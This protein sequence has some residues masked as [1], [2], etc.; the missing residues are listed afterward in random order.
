MVFAAPMF[1]ISVPVPLR[2]EGAPLGLT[3]DEAVSIEEILAQHEDPRVVEGAAEE[4]A[5]EKLSYL[6]FS[7]IAFEPLRNW[8]GEVRS[9]A[10]ARPIEAQLLKGASGYSGSISVTMAGTP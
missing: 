4:V 2:G 8:L 10:R 9:A 1:C 5:Q 3:D 7:G 6:T